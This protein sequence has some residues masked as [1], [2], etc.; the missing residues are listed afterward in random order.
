M[1]RLRAFIAIA[2]FIAWAMSSQSPLAQDRGTFS[3]GTFE[4]DGTP[5]LGI[6]LRDDLVIDLARALADAPSSPRVTPPQDMKAL[7]GRYDELRDRIAAIVARVVAADAKRP[8]YVMKLAEVRVRPPIMYPTTML[9]VAV[10]YREHA[11]ETN[12]GT[13]APN[14]PGTASPDTKS[15]PGIWERR[16]DDSRW[17][18]Y[19]FVKL[20][21]AVIASGEAI[22]LPPGRTQIDWE[23][24]L[25]V[26]IGRVASRVPVDRAAE[27]IFGYTIENDVSDRGGR[28]DSR[29]GSDWLIAKSHDTFAPMGPAIVPKE[30]VPDPQKLPIRFRLNGQLMQDSNTSLMIHTVF[31]QIAYA[32]S[33]TTLHPGDVLSTGTPGGVGSARKPPIFLKP[34]DVTACSYEGIG[35]LTNSV[36][37]SDA[38]SVSR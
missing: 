11:Q 37:G 10:N 35:T 3:L 4:R 19:M 25:G 36:V 2:A 23:C 6:V 15:V 16:P 29:H 1:T 26:V 17:N 22:R 34:G 30:F 9:N 7:I 31:E 20:P 28:G 33:I 21:S 32:S 13:G 18:P 5:F 27:F 8:A 38:S 14:G 24:E 12:T